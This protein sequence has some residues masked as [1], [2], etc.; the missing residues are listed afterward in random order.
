MNTATR[1]RAQRQFAG[2]KVV[3]RRFT[4]G[5]PI[6]VRHRFVDSRIEKDA[7]ATTSPFMGIAHAATAADFSS[8]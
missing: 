1:F 5:G 8:I 6:H 2:P 7:F 3:A 4:S